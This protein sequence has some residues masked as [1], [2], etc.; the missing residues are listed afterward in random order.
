MCKHPFFNK[1]YKI[2]DYYQFP[3]RYIFLM[4]ECLFAISRERQF[5]EVNVVLLFVCVN[6][7]DLRE[8]RPLNH[9]QKQCR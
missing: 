7:R 3:Y 2:R 4:H 1:H 6:Q 8:N 9:M 5:G